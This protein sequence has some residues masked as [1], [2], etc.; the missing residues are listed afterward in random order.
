MIKLSVITINYNNAKGLEKTIQ[1]VISQTF[2]DYEY[3]IIDGGSYDGSK[4]IIEKQTTKIT[5]W[6]SEK[7]KGIYNAMNKGIKQAKGEYCLFLNSGDFLC[8]DKVLEEVFVITSIADI[9][10]GNMM[11][12]WGNGKKTEGKMPD[13]ITTQQMYND[14]LW[15]PVSFIKRELFDKYGLYNEAYKIVADYDFFFKTIIANKVSTKHIP[16]LVSVYNVDGFS[17]KSENKVIEKEERTRVIQTYLSQEEINYLEGITQKEKK[18]KE[19]PLKSLL[20]KWF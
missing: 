13:T 2:I 8:S 19:N 9:I 4:E 6:V 20:K 10:Y 18:K 7:D 15:H 14:T 11:I 17:S 12:D 1:S 5:Y 3:I 16:L